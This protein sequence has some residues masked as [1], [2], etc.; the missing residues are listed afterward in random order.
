M[1]TLKNPGAFRAFAKWALPL[2]A[3]LGVLLLIPAL[4]LGLVSS[5][6]DYQQGETVRIMY[7]HVPAASGSLLLYVMLGIA[8]FVAFVW[9][10]TMA[11]IFCAAAAPVGAVLAALCLITGSLWGK[12]MWGTWWVWDARLTSMLILFFFYLGAV[13]LRSAFADAVRGAKAGQILLILGLINVPIVKFSVDWWNTLHQGASLF[14]PAGPA[15]AGPMLTP[16]LV[17]M[18]A[19]FFLCV[20]LILMRMLTLMA[21][22]AP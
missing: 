20:A 19:G 12:P 2:S 18:G 11:D 6:A 15:I 4:Y 8:A 21:K 10:H 7:V 1:K 17:A 3:M 14:R 5:P 22:K 9:K 13:V 16:L